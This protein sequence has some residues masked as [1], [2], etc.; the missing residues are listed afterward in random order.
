MTCH[1]D[2][3]RSDEVRRAVPVL[4]V[5][6]GGIGDPAVRH[7]GTLGGSAAADPAADYPAA[8]VGLEASIETTERSIAADE[9]FR[10]LFET[11]LGPAEIITGVRFTIPDDAR[12]AKVR[13]PA[14]GYPVAGVMVARFGE[15]VRVAVTGAGPA[16]FRVGEVEAA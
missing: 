16:V 14:S 7:R 2:V 12:Y 8:L 6:A 10:G 1:F 9:F 11:A 13:H 5:L 4:A 3:A 15:R